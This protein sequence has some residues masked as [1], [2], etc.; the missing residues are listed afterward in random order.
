[1]KVAIVS[2]IHS[3]IEALEAVMKDI[4]SK[5]DI[6]KIC[7]LGDLVGY[8][9]NP[10]EVL[11]VAR[12]QFKACIL[13]N[14]D[15]AVLKEPKYFNR[16]PEEAIYWTKDILEEQGSSADIQYLESLENLFREE[17]YVLSHGI[18][19]D[20]MSYTTETEDLFYI[21]EN[22]EPSE[23]VCFGGH[24]HQPALWVLED[25]ELFF[26]EP[27]LDHDFKVDIESQKCWVNVGSV[28]Q[29]R[30]SDT[31]ASYVIYDT[32]TN[33]INFQK[34]E[35]DFEITANK[36]RNIDGLD[37]FLGDRLTKGV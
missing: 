28:G 35:Y 12:E 19:E 6:D 2:D 31:R 23:F 7:C 8:G 25:D 16:I 22:M 3:N 5:N 24:S 17:G 15:E 20:N 9:P 18:M 14:H 21:F 37:N 11:K 27:E 4:Q 32:K 13:G 10:V 34:V 26:F 1:V 33:I 29:P 36:I 30:D